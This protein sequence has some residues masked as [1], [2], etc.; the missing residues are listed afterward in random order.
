MLRGSS[1]SQRKK[2]RYPCSKA[3]K[4]YLMGRFRG[5]QREKE[6]FGGVG[7]EEDRKTPSRVFS[8]K[9]VRRGAGDTQLHASEGL[10]PGKGLVVLPLKRSLA[11]SG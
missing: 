1:S 3:R 7:R 8:Q 4:I 10:S 2:R 11:A 5:L 6:R 9:P